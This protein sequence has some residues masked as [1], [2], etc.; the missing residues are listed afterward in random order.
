LERQK[1][2][3]IIIRRD[4]SGLLVNTKIFD[5]EEIPRKEICNAGK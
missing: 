3:F 1:D 5:P 4:V 2:V